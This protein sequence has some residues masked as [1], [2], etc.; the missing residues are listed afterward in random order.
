M[1]KRRATDEQIVRVLRQAEGEEKIGEVCRQLGI[2]EQTYYTWKCKYA[3][4]GLSELGELRQSPPLNPGRDQS[5]L[6][7]ASLLPYS[8]AINYD[9]RFIR[10]KMEEQP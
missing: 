4:L 10:D 8:A 2:S 1:G 5:H 9:S 6:S 7:Q 3:D